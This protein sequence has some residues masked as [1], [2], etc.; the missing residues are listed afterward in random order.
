MPDHVGNGGLNARRVVQV[1][2]IHCF[3]MVGISGFEVIVQNPLADGFG[4][5]AY[6][7]YCKRFRS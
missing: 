6:A 1:F 3:D 5:F 2:R 4:G 7:D